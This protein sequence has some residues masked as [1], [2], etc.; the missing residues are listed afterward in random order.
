MAANR[1]QMFDGQAP[2]IPKVQ[3]VAPQPPPVKSDDDDDEVEPM[4]GND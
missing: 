2:Q 4:N 1:P 3:E